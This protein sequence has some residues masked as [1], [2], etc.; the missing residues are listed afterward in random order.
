MR[1]IRIALGSND[2]E[3][4]AP[5]HMGMAADF[6]IYDLSEDGCSSFVG[7][8]ENT[9]PKVEGKHGLPEK[10][11]A[12][13]EIFKDADV[14][15]GRRKSPNFRNIG[16]STKFQPVVVEADKISAIIA[17]LANRFDEI[18]RLVEQRRKGHRSGQI[19]LLQ[20]R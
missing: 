4:I 5:S 17:K 15:V 8:R 12:V 3:K 2:G 9:S 10:M 18:Y 11:K 14:I 16:A 19:P 20:E 7:K 1:K 6:Y 13:M